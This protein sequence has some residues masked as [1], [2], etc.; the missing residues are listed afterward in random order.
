MMHGVVSWGRM[1]MHA[2]WGPG[3]HGRARGAA[4]VVGKA[5][6]LVLLARLH[7][8]VAELLHVEGL[9][10]SQ[11]LLSLQLQLWGGGEG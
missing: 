7:L 11:E 6:L 2:G 1:S 5:L 10:L 4:M 8:R 3:G 9:A